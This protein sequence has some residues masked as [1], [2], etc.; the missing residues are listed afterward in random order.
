MALTRAAKQALKADVAEKFKNSKTTII[1]EY[2]GLT[3]AELTQLRAKLREAEAEFKVVKNRVAKVAIREDAPEAGVISDNLKGPVGVVFVYGDTAAA[4]KSLVDF[5]KDKEAF[6]VTA[7]VM[8]GKAISSADLRA[9]A[10]LPS[11]EVLLG[12]IV[13]LLVA[14]HRGLL[15][16]I[17]GVPRQ[18]V[19]VINA[20]KDLKSK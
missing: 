1:A 15:G 5:E 13:G 9:I 3:V 19:Q 18:L 12:Q 6:K 10:S 16:V 11:K 8:E 7:G 4:A 2:R 14:P 17:N 20:I